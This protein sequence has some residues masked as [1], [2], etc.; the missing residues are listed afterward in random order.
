MKQIE[1]FV[2]SAQKAS[3]MLIHNRRNKFNLTVY[4]G[5]DLVEPDLN[6]H[7]RSEHVSASHPRGDILQ[8]S[9]LMLR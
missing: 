1:K 5:E 8:Q 9:L 7:N 2:N 6:F 4:V 3:T